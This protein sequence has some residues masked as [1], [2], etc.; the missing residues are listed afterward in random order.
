MQR[1]R[2]TEENKEVRA[3]FDAETARKA[4]EFIRQAG[5]VAVRQNG[6][7]LLCMLADDT[8]V[9]RARKML[10]QE[11]R[12]F[13]LMVKDAPMAER[14]AW[15]CQE[16]K[17]LLSSKHRPT[18][19][20]RK[21]NRE[22]YLGVSELDSI[23]VAL[24]STRLHSSM[25]EYLDEPMAFAGCD[26]KDEM[27]V[28]EREDC[29]LLSE[30]NMPDRTDDSVLKVIRGSS[31]F[32]KRSRGYSSTPVAMPV[33]CE[34]TLALGAELNSAFCV[35]KSREAFL[36]DHIGDT[37][38]LE[39]LLLLR[40]R[41]Q[42]AIQS[43]GLSP[44]IIACDAHPSYNSSLLARE[45]AREF[46]AKLTEVQHHKAHVASAAAE[47]G[48]TDYVGIAA[49][50]LGYGDDG[51]LWGGEVFDVKDSTGFERIGSLEEQPQIGGD[52]ASLYPKK[53]LFGILSK[54]L[55][56]NRLE[57][58]RLFDEEET[59]FYLRMLSDKFNVPSTTSAGRVL[60]AVAALLGLCDFRA[61]EGRPAMLV[62][63]VAT[64]PIALEPEF[65]VMKG[66]RV[67]LTTE[68]FRFLL[69]NIESSKPR[70]AATAQSYLAE[71][72]YQMA[73]ERA[74]G[75]PIVFSGGVACNRMISGFML[76][77]GVLVN[78]QLP[79][80]DGGICYGQAYLANLL[81]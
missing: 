25:L 54:I 13:S 74:G 40:E 67:L 20:L 32:L 23:G 36:S 70:L 77:R 59:R 26:A 76:E 11:H 2:L 9:D 52:S 37:S 7:I 29:L 18:V 69:D 57:G 51:S 64:E 72:L 60:D 62:E 78:R 43:K 6:D 56:K 79:C 71:G 73:A 35:V 39:G 8:T 30:Q 49:D 46:H 58:L 16:E 19:I 42:G 44:R 45:L 5:I 80:G 66:R 4:A 55:D 14:V 34:E 47:H 68:L 12:P 63:S 22:L 28:L 21:R 53:M 50:G 75:R 33:E 61:Y 17:E 38:R 81:H 15:L 3:G 24:P 27:A 41:V 48:L 1:L 65:A 31:L 10:N